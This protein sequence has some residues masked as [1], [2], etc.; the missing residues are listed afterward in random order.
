[1]KSSPKLEPILFSCEIK[2]IDP[3]Q[4]F[5]SIKRSIGG[6]I[7]DLVGLM[8]ELAGEKDG[9]ETRRH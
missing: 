6:N 2:R 5:E 4:D 1:M 3:D 8:F 9:L 7:D